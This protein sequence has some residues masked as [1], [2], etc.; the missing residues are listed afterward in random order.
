MNRDLNPFINDEYDLIKRV[1]FNQLNSQSI[2]SI[3]T[4]VAINT[5]PV[6]V[7]VQPCIKYFDRNEGFQIPPILGNV[8]IAQVSNNLFSVK[9]PVNIGDVGIIL[10]FDREVYSWLLD[11][12]ASPKEPESGT[13][14]NE[15]ACIFLPFLQKFSVSPTLAQTGVDI[16]SSSVSLMTQLIT[17]LT[18]LNTFLASL[19]TAGA[20]YAGAPTMPVVGAYPIAVTAAATLLETA[21]TTITSAL[22]T[23]KGAQP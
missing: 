18:D 12:S 7:D 20:P 1:M 10:W 3:G 22:T 21:V 6:S 2:C 19:I 11:P 16:E 4:I 14:H 13:L 23:F 8:P 17:L 15:A 9:T 5:S